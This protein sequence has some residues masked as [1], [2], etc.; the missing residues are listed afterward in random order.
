MNI[1]AVIKAVRTARQI[2]AMDICLKVGLPIDSL[3]NIE[4]GERPIAGDEVQR[5]ADALGVPLPVLLYLAADNNELEDIG[6][7]SAQKLADIVMSLIKQL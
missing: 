2:P 3:V 7:E 1:G 4:R 6:A 5:F